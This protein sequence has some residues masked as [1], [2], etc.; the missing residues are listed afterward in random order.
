M[1]WFKVLRYYVQIKA[2]CTTY[3]LHVL[4]RPAT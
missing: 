3:P 2:F 4:A 1:G